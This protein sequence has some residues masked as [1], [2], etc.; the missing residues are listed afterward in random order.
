MRNGNGAS[1]N[2][3]RRPSSLLRRCESATCMV[4][5]IAGARH[6]SRRWAEARPRRTA[7]GLPSAD[8]AADEAG[9]GHHRQTAGRRTAERAGALHRMPG[10]RS[11]DRY[12][13]RWQVS[14]T[15]GPATRA[16]LSPSSLAALSRAIRLLA[17]RAEQSKTLARSV[18]HHAAEPP[19]VI[20]TDG[21][22]VKCG[23]IRGWR[24]CFMPR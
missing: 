2:S 18:K 21:R 7:R 16:A 1:G 17:E 4:L 19:I 20:E 11:L 9:K 13:Q 22:E 3:F 24:L 5:F 8:E 12:A 10:V 14:A 23:L 6:R 15:N